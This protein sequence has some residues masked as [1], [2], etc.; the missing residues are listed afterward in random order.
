MFEH[1]EYDPHTPIVHTHVDVLLHVVVLDVLAFVFV[2]H[3]FDTGHV[4]L[5]VRVYFPLPHVFEHVEYD[6]HA[7]TVHTHVDV[8]LHV[9]VLDVLAFVF[10]LH[11]PL[12]GHVTLRVRVYVPLPHVF[13]H[14]EYDSPCSQLVH[15]H[16]DVLLHV[17][18]LDVLAFVFVL[19]PLDTGH[20][21]VRVRVY[22]PLPHVFEHVEYDPQLPIVHTHVDVLLHVDVLDVLA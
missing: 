18:V 14:V 1:V 2:L 17:D 11:P 20:V 12:T 9:D 13:E 16:V 10:V 22:V 21:T 19:H 6:P 3:P 15:T 5:R 4:T 7:P 8:L